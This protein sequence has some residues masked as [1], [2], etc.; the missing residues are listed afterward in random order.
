VRADVNFCFAVA[1]ISPGYY[2]TTVDC[3]VSNGK[4]RGI[5]SSPC[6]YAAIPLP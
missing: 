5:G 2:I 1:I 3:T 6:P 4:N